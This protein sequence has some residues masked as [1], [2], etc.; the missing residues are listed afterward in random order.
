MSCWLSLSSGGDF[1]GWFEVSRSCTGWMLHIR[2]YLRPR[3][4]TI[5][6]CHYVHHPAR[7]PQLVMYIPTLELHTRV[8]VQSLMH[9]PLDLHDAAG[10][11]DQMD[12]LPCFLPCRGLIRGVKHRCHA[13]TAV[14]NVIAKFKGDGSDCHIIFGTCSRERWSFLGLDLT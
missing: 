7:Y 14:R 5:P 3:E 13:E 6:T 9:H 11:C 12:D 8:L 1:S 10:R 4:A 2:T